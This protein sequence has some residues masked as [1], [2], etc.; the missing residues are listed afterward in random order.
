MPRR[1]RYSGSDNPSDGGAPRF[2][3]DNPER[4]E[5]PLWEE[6]VRTGETAFAARQRLGVQTSTPMWCFSRFGMSETPLPDGRTVFIGGEHEDYYDP[7]FYIYNDVIVRHPD[8]RIEIYGYPRST[9]PPTDFHSAT[10]FDD[11]IIVIGSAGYAKERDPL[12]TPVFRL[13]L[14]TYRMEQLDTGRP[15]PGWIH[16][17]SAELDGRVIRVSGGQRVE[18]HGAVLKIVAN[19]QAYDL[20]T[21]RFRWR[22]VD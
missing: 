16:K 3:R 20:H 22:R 14:L 2:G 7:D 5:A 11:A 8:D 10:L 19:T 1:Q 12:R 9:F 18:Q 6:L 13:D 21:D 4:M 17:H 15:N